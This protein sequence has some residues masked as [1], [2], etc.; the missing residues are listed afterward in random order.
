MKIRPPK[1]HLAGDTQFNMTAMI[2]VVF[3]L[4]IFFMLI[5]QFIVQENYRL[6][7]PDDCSN[8]VKPK[9]SEQGIITLSVFPKSKKTAGTEHS[10]AETTSVPAIY[11]VRAMQFD[12]QN[13]M[14]RQNTAKLVND[15]AE[16][17]KKE[18][19][20]KNQSVVY[21]RVDKELEYLQVQKALMAL[22]MAQVKNVRFAAFGNEQPKK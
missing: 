11:A 21:L 7:I 4:I 22:A 20:R 5:C 9:Q 17:L 13:E 14:Y 16:Q 6:T 8:A 1:L 12:P 2:D 18:L 19:V 3:L 15:I 10:Q